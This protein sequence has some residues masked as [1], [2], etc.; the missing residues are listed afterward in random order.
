MVM[1]HKDSM[2]EMHRTNLI[3]GAERVK[4]HD[5]FVAT[6]NRSG[7]NTGMNKCPFSGAGLV[8]L[9]DRKWANATVTTP[10]VVSRNDDLPSAL[11]R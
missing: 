10:Y 4:W 5:V 6:A 3:L 11:C 9:N 8:P 7:S 1:P 2:V